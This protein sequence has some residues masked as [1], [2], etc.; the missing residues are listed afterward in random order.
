MHCISAIPL[1]MCIRTAQVL[2]ILY[3]ELFWRDVFVFPEGLDHVAAVRETGCLADVGHIVIG[4]E[5]HVLS[6]DHTDIF[7]VLLA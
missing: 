4:K 5:Q 6:F 3:P 2:G 7:D 1:Q